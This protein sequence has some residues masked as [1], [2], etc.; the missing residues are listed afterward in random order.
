MKYLFVIAVIAV[1]LSSCCIEGKMEATRASLLEAKTQQSLESGQL[2]AAKNLAGAKRME[3]YI[4]SVIENRVHAK[5]NKLKN[6]IEPAGFMITSLDSLL[7]NKKNF[8][9]KYKT[10]IIPTVDSLKRHAAMYSERNKLYKMVEEGL[11]NSKYQLFDLAAFFGP[12]KYAIPDD[13]KELAEASFSPIIDSIFS[14]SNKHN[15][16]GT[17]SLVVLGF[18]DGTGFSSEGPLF[19][20]LT[21]LIGRTDVSK[22]ELNSKL[23]ELR[24]SELIKHLSF[25]YSKK[26][27]YSTLSV[28][29]EVEYIGLG[30]GE[31][32]PLPTIKDYSVDDPRRRIVLC[33]WI[34]LPD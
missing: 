12:G 20:T 31:A 19:D 34:V 32:Y 11:S 27:E 5:L 10:Y 4:D 18:A 25:I 16:K 29:P 14:F 24:A 26:G 3:G 23:S 15:I 1:A 22:Q 7:A 13:K 9:K 30:K 2:V 28:K 33:Y 6:G 21:A 17:A 8:R